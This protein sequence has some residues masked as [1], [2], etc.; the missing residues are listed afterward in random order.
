MPPQK[1]FLFL[2]LLIATLAL[3]ACAT[4]VPAPTTATQAPAT[5]PASDQTAKSDEAAATAT[6]AKGQEDAQVG[7]LPRFEPLD[8]CFAA[9]PEDVEG[10]FDVDCG[11][12]VVPEFHQQESDR[13]LKLGI[14]RFNSGEGE[15]QS[16]LFI[17]AGGPGQSLIGPIAFSLM[18]PGLL[19]DILQ[20]H[21]VV[22][23]DQRGVKHTAPYLDCPDFLRALGG[24]S[25]GLE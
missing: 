2:A 21:D 12:V 4:V 19:G 5:K 20:T 16:P 11:Y 22:F 24:L 13:E 14:M 10:S 8:D 1:T 6:P 15:S 25:A 18:Q 7:K 23:I 17:L 9:P 3:A